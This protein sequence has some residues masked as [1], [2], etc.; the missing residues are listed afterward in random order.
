MGREDVDIFQ[1]VCLD[2]FGQCRSGKPGD[3]QARVVEPRLTG[4]LG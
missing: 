4:L 3:V 2:A 1:A